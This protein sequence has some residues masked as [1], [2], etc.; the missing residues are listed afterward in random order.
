M[1]KPGFHRGPDADH[2]VAQREKPRR[3]AH[4]WLLAS[5]WAHTNAVLPPAGGAGNDPQNLRRFP[6][7]K[8]DGSR[9]GEFETFDI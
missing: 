7:P 4:C 9:V 1:G 5:S 8:A 6:E 3:Y 2:Y